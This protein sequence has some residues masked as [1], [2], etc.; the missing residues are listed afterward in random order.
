[1]SDDELPI[2]DEVQ[3]TEGAIASSPK[4]D[5][6]PT[7]VGKQHLRS[8]PITTEAEETGTAQVGTRDTVEAPR[9]DLPDDSAVSSRSA[10]RLAGAEGW[11]RNGPGR[12]P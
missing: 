10:K 3:T 5:Q 4:A 7:A 12:G 8:T 9:G 2:N 1:M 11:S 6:E